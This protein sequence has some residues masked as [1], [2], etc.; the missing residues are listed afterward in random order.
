MRSSTFLFIVD[1]VLASK[2]LSLLL[3]FLFLSSQLI[4]L[5]I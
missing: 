5:I 4:V 2:S 3:F 1:E